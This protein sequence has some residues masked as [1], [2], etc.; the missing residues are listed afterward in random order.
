MNTE[1][2]TINTNTQTSKANA[3]R[4][5]GLLNSAAGRSAAA[6]IAA[7]CVQ[8][9]YWCLS[10]ALMGSTYSDYYVSRWDSE[11]MP[12]LLRGHACVFRS[13]RDSIT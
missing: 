11:T 12:V 13:T 8:L 1:L 2:N 7:L 4:G 5:S 6:T 9:Y 3:T 10:D